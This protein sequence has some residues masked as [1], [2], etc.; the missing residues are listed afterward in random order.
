[1]LS[2]PTACTS[3]GQWT[4]CPLVILAQ[5]LATCPS[6]LQNG[7]LPEVSLQKAVSPLNAADWAPGSAG[8]EE[9]ETFGWCLLITYFIGVSLMRF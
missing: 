7:C 1:M 3:V 2:V 8:A 4:V 9:F 5:A 6:H